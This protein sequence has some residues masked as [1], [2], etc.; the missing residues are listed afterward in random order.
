M[1]RVPV[2]A[3]V[4]GVWLAARLCAAQAES[5]AEL[6]KAIA[7][8]PN[9]AELHVKLAAAL[10]QKR[11][12]AGAIP[13]LRRAL[14]L[15]PDLAEA[16]GLLGQA[17]L[18]QGY[19]AAAIPHLERG[20]KL[21]LLGMALAEEHRAPEAIE[22]LLA[23]LDAKPN[24]PDLLFHLGRAG[25]LLL[26]SSFDRLI[27]SHPGSPRAHQLMA[28]T[29][30]AQRQIEAAEREYRQA[31]EMRPDLRG[32]HLALG[33][34]KL[35]AGNLDEAEQEFRAE[36]ALSPGDGEA[37]WRLGSVLLQKGRTQEALSELERS[38]RLRP[39]MIETLY[40]LGKACALDNK[41]AAAEQR[42]LQLLAIDDT[43]ELAASAHLR[44]SQLYRRQ[45]KTAEADRHFQRFQQLQPRSLQQP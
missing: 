6:K 7:A 5:I 4:L 28:E 25:G 36:A 35:N 42:W 26:R 38:D 24:D 29:Y 20:Q 3:C 23:A 32:I 18:A 30:A 15:Q 43:S 45:G 10:E 40:D 11:D 37:A 27:R 19:S 8:S 39:Q 12:Y 17:L 31:L 2:Q 41:P 14:E 21:D 34:L 1:T 22:K 13:E 9:R 44:L 16:H 33:M